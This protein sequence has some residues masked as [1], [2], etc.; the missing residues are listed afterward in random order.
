[1]PNI[2]ATRIQQKTTDHTA[3]ESN[4]KNRTAIDKIE[5]DKD[6]IENEESQDTQLEGED[7]DESYEKEE[8]TENYKG[9]KE[10]ERKRNAAATR[11]DHHKAKIS[12]FV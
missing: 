11:N 1:M 9:D 10:P 6:G 3:A 4:R 5:Y 8:G 2:H 7:V 12:M